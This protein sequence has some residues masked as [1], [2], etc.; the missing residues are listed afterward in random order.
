MRPGLVLSTAEF[1]GLGLKEAKAIAKDVATVPSG[2]RAIAAAAGA[3][4]T[5]I[6]RLSSAFQHNDLTRAPAL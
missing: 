1:F 3:P 2:W 5:E 6:R 4:Q